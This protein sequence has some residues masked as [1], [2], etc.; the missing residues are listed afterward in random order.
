[1]WKRN[2]AVQLEAIRTLWKGMYVPSDMY[3]VI[4]TYVC[5]RGYAGGSCAICVK[6]RV[7]LAECKARQNTSIYLLWVGPKNCCFCLPCFRSIEK[8]THAPACSWG[9]LHFRVQLIFNGLLSSG[10]TNG[11]SSAL[12]KDATYENSFFAHMEIKT[13]FKWSRILPTT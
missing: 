12:A 8:V 6:L 1:M 13:N 5:V 7:N 4:R 11:M 2:V 9:T 3:I 10:I